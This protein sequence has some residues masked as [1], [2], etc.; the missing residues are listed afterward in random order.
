LPRICGGSVGDYQLIEEHGADGRG[1]LTLRVHPRVGGRD[2]AML[3]E[4]LRRELAVGSRGKRLMTETWHEAG[5]FR[6][7]REPPEMSARGK[8][9][10]VITLVSHRRGVSQG[11]VDPAREAR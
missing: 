3:V 1:Y 6:I 9:P 7:V 5:A 8:T 10:A 4:V 2:D 11:R